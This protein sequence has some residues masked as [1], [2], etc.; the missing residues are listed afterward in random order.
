SKA[1]AY[2][3]SDGHGLLVIVTLTKVK[4]PQRLNDA[5]GKVDDR[6]HRLAG[7]LRAAGQ[8]QARVRVGG[9]LALN[10]EGNQVIQ[11]D[12]TQ[13]EAVSLPI[14]L[15]VLVFVFG[16]LAAAGLPVLVALVSVTAAMTLMLVLSKVIDTTTDGV[17]IVTLLGLGLS[18][19]YGLLLV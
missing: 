3:S 16:G 7:E 5:V 2:I 6:I 18:I 19:D 13:A 11:E 15:L 9:K 14:P 1:R 17:T 12:M 4:N 8:A 10:R